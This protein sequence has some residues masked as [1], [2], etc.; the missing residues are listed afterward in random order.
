[1]GKQIKLY[2][3]FDTAE[4]RAF[5]S[6]VQKRLAETGMIDVLDETHSGSVE[7]GSTFFVE[8]VL[9]DGSWIAQGEALI[10]EMANFKHEHVRV[11]GVVRAQWTVASIQHV[12]NCIDGSGLLKTSE[13]FKV[14]LR[15][16]EGKQVVEVEVTPGAFEEI[17]RR[18]GKGIQ[19][20]Q[21]VIRMLLEE[22]LKQG[23][24]SY[25]HPIR[26]PKHRLDHLAAQAMIY[27]IE[28]PDAP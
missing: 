15:A 22:N 21:Q 18:L 9:H 28:H 8:L 24:Q 27:K 11:V 20:V 13:C 4:F 19:I 26:N 12:G 2:P 1:M 23:G 16:G 14:E 17:D 3:S 5:C 7:I 6:L 10:L 25:W